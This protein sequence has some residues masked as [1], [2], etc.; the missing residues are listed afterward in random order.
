VK[1]RNVVEEHVHAAFDTLRPHFPGFCGCE[2]CNAD[3]LVFGLNR[4]PPRY[5]ATREG[6]VLTELSL[7]RDQSRA[8]IDV[9]V[10]EGFRKVMMAP[11]CGHAPARPSA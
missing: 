4:V 10:M 5:V 3:V 8:A 2:V 11:R 9:V 7:E 1:I 6:M